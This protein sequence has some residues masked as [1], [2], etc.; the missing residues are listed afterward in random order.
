VWGKQSTGG[1]QK[2]PERGKRSQNENDKKWSLSKT[3]EVRRG[4]LKLEGTEG[5]ERAREGR[6]TACATGRGFKPSLP[7]EP[8]GKEETKRGG[9]VV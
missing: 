6:K 1:D 3:D 5:G 8:R 7:Q 4:V 2:A 9:G